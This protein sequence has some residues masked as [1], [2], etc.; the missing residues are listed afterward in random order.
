MNSASGTGRGSLKIRRML[1]R[2]ASGPYPQLASHMFS[3]AHVSGIIRSAGSALL[4]AEMVIT[5]VVIY[6]NP[7]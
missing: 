3:C 2:R 7:P 6:L 5:S 1:S 4:A